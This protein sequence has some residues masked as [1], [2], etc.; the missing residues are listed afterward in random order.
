LLNFEGY[1]IVFFDLVDEA[2]NVNKYVFVRTFHLNETES[3]GL[4]KKLYFTGLH[5]LFFIGMN[6]LSRKYNA[7]IET[8]KTF[9]HIYSDAA[10]H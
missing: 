8:I 4:I 10:Q 1:V 6:I 3:F 2:R 9:F 7:V 5:Y